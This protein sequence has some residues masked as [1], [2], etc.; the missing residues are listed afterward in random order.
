MVFFFYYIPTVGSILAIVAPALLTL[1]QFDHL[2]PFLI[3]L[4]VIGTIQIVMA[5]VVEPAIMGRSLNLSP[6]VVIVSL[7]VWGTIWGVVGMFLCV[8]IMVVVLIVL[9]HFGDHA[10]SRSPAVGR[11][12]DPRAAPSDLVVMTPTLRA[13]LQDRPAASW[14]CHRHRD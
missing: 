13:R 11:R 3:V 7:M 8:P 2:T 5:N 10:P 1:V 4:L 12:C 9:A 14:S 6:L